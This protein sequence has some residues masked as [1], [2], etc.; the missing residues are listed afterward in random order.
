MS[1]R[2]WAA[3]AAAA[4]AVAAALVLVVVMTAQRRY[5]RAFAFRM[6]RT[7]AAYI[8]AVT[9]PPP[10]PPPP[11][12][13]LRGR[14]RTRAPQPPPPPPPPAPAP[15]P[16]SAA[17]RSYDLPA[18]LTQA[19]AL[20]TLPGWSSDV[21]VYFGTAPLVDATAAP[22]SPDDLL[23]LDS[24]GRWRDGAALVP[25]KDRDGQEVVGAVAVRPRP[26][27]H[28]PLPGGFGFTF[29]AAIVAV[30][31]AATIAFR[32][33]SLRNGGYVG[34]ALLLALAAYGDVRAAARQSTDRWL[35]DTG[36]LL[37]E[38]ATRLPP[39]RV[40]VA[41]TDLATLVR[42]AE[43]VAGQPPESP[44][45]R[46]KIDGERRAVVAV[47]IGS[48]RWIE[49]RSVPAEIEAPKWLIL[50]GP[51]ALL[52][53]IAIMAL[54][55]AERTPARRRRETVIAWGFLAPAALHLMIFTIGPAIYAIYLA[56][57]ANFR[58]L[59]RDPLTWNSFVT[60]AAY[61]LYVP[62]SVALALAAALAVHRYRRRWSGRLVG[63]AFLLPYVAS[64]VAV[65]LLWQAIYRAGSLGM[66]RPDWLSNP[67]TALLALMV[68]SIWVHVGG[69]MLVFLG[70]LE[71]IPQ[72]YFDAALVDGAGAWRRL[73]RVTLPLLRPVT[74]FVVLTGVISALQMFTLVFVLTQGGPFPLHA[75]DVVVHRIYRTAFGP[76][77]FGIASALAV[78]LGVVLLVFRWPQL[79]LLR[80]RARHA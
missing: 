54:R 23:H 35:V 57:L 20:R 32:Q 8:A 17:A 56:S 68:V 79:K 3:S 65:A 22:L 80:R 31:A 64:V 62:V 21:E 53:P 66:G 71:A 40:R 19:R 55:W 70:G 78:M 14:R 41:I 34:A 28:G 43:I 76:Q 29:P 75:T 30:G 27:P 2:A 61:A 10:P 36:R 48:G 52:G 13:A 9:P 33:R 18:L 7:T 26:A 15:A 60:S 77:A 37:K 45:R 74:W 16:L 59:L 49:L 72:T 67:N 51:C 39:P 42:D 73:W 63:A 50:L 24:G 46:V 12:P 1:S 5:E 4:A 58:A 11:R 47:L 25:L 38:A 69:Q 44:P 6:A